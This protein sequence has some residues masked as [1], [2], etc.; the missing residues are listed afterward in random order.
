M[1]MPCD[2]DTMK[3]AKSSDEVSACFKLPLK[4]QQLNINTKNRNQLFSA[5]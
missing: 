3:K 1:A 5:F 4:T 2:T